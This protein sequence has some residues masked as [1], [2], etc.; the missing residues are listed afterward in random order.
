MPKLSVVDMINEV[1]RIADTGEKRGIHLRVMGGA[2]I[3]IHCP[4]YVELYQTL[5][6]EFDDV[7]FVALQKQQKKIKPVMEDL[8]YKLQKDLLREIEHKAD[9]TDKHSLDIYYDMGSYFRD[10]FHHTMHGL[11]AD[12]FYD[13]IEMCHTIDLTKRLEIDFPTISVSDILLAKLQ[14]VEI[15]EKDV[16]DIITLMLEHDVS[17]GDKETVNVEYLAK[18]FSKDWGF[19][20]TATTN[21]KK[22]QD[23]AGKYVPEKDIQVLNSRILKLLETIEKEPKGL[24]WKARAAVGTKKRWYQEVEFR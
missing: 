1:S 6:R 8:G 5:R 18:L 20:H 10:I 4:K 19:Y 22:V 12:I 21:L 24:S 2:A 7:D 9:A 14:I 11:V 15:N 13:K 3:R 17:Q 16:K 23:L